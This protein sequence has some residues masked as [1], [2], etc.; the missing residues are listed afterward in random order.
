MKRTLTLLFALYAVSLPVLTAFDRGLGNPKA[1]FI[2][3]GQY[4]A[5]ISGSYNNWDASAGDDLT[6][7]ISLF[8]IAKDINGD[9]ALF[10]I[11]AH[12]SWF[13]K[14]NM[15]IGAKLVYSNTNVDCNNLSV[16]SLLS[17]SDKHMRSE[18]YSALVTA[19]Y[20]MPLFN[21][22]FLAIFG[23]AGLG[24]TVGYSKNYENTDRGKSGTFTNQYSA[25]FNIRFG[26]A[27]FVTDFVSIEVSV[28]SI[29][30]AMR[31]SDSLEKQEY[32]SKLNGFSVKTG[33]NILGIR[34]GVVIYH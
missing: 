18:S 12:G 25:D 27:L 8:G 7:G 3:K 10:S 1:T 6:K 22:K 28:P 9:A 17:V 4:S 34:F 13:F 26:A 20:Y 24:G 14:D 23:E 29:S 19:K 31:W 16:L 33:T 11:D 21:T 32:E 30:A 2:P 5:G 15:S